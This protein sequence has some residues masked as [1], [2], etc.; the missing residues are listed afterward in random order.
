M[1]TLPDAASIFPEYHCITL[2]FALV[3]YIE[4]QKGVCDAS[5]IAIVNPVF[6]NENHMV[7]GFP[8]RMI[9]TA[10]RLPGMYSFS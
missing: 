9:E 2:E 3:R 5:F 10:V 7:F 1:V 6:R 8:L 4:S